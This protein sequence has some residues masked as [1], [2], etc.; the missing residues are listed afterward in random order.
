MDINPNDSS[1]SYSS[2]SS[3][4]FPPPDTSPA[5]PT[6]PVD[7]TP[8]RPKPQWEQRRTSIPTGPQ[9]NADQQVQNSVIKRL[10]QNPE[11]AANLTA[12]LET[13]QQINEYRL[14]KQEVHEATK[15]PGGL[16]KLLESAREKRRQTEEQFFKVFSH[17]KPEGAAGTFTL[18]EEDHLQDS[19]ESSS[20]ASGASSGSDVTADISVDEGD[21]ERIIGKQGLNSPLSEQQIREAARRGELRGVAHR[22]HTIDLSVRSQ[23]PLS[24]I[25]MQ[26]IIKKMIDIEKRQIDLARG[27]A[28]RKGQNPAELVGHHVISQEHGIE[29]YVNVAG[30]TYLIDTARLL[31]KGAFKNV[32][33]ALDAST[34]NWIALGISQ[35]VADEDDLREVER[36]LAVTGQRGL[37]G[38][39][40]K[41][42]SQINPSSLK[43]EN[44]RLVLAMPI[45]DG[46]L[47]SHIPTI[48]KMPT[49]R[50][51]FSAVVAMRDTLSGL[52]YLHGHSQVHRDIKPANVGMF[53]DEQGNVT[54]AK[55]AD[56]GLQDDLNDSDRSPAG[57]P[58]YMTPEA[59][60]GES[61]RTNDL[62]AMGLT[63]LPLVSGKEISTNDVELMDSCV[64]A[65]RHLSD[66]QKTIDLLQV[67]WKLTADHVKD[68]KALIS[69]NTKSKDKLVIMNKLQQ[70]L[71]LQDSDMEIL[72]ALRFPSNTSSME[73]LRGAI[74]VIWAGAVD[75]LRQDH[76]LMEDPIE[77][78]DPYIK[79]S[80]E[81]RE[82][83]AMLLDPDLDERGDAQHIAEQFTA[84][85]ESLVAE[86]DRRKASPS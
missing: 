7:S 79:A 24:P 32:F 85:H 37:L 65:Q 52:A 47:K 12:H 56:F 27:E 31:G 26:A 13:R 77:S 38:G 68:L 74:Q 16:K 75:K 19:H 4:G 50:R 23:I 59:L 46:D 41:T 83:C 64:T 86:N 1:H 82:T 84:I 58:R 48:L 66:P 55:I 49:E 43:T 42:V 10:K 78:D 9:T 53:L 63:L 14:S 44:S 30:A 36:T 54:A 22:D 40:T 17:L 18:S 6:K 67:K 28:P 21:I 51:I 11:L 71:N 34:N 57:T 5:L 15:T 35:K 62:W 72:E 8:T 3:S 73:A 45:H 69:K 80:N 60:R 39:I 2:D 76:G 29:A 25:Q 70:S 33:R 81:L 20:D 61:M